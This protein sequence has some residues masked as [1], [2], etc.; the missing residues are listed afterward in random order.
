MWKLLSRVK[1]EVVPRLDMDRLRD[2]IIGPCLIVVA[3]SRPDVFEYL[4][5]QFAADPRVEFIMDRRA[6]FGR[7]RTREWV[8][9]DRRRGDRRKP[10]SVDTDQT[11]PN[12]VVIP[13]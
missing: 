7:R 1:H 11:Q 13:R 4:Q 6:G 2:S 8:Q 5:Q 12:F 9:V 10:V 3:P